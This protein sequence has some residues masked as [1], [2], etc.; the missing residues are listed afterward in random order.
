MN[1]VSMVFS[2]ESITGLIPDMNWLSIF[3]L[4]ELSVSFNFVITFFSNETTSKERSLTL[5]S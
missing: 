5:V 1:L 3:T 2:I 4:M